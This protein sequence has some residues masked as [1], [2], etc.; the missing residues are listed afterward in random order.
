MAYSTKPSLLREIE[1]EGGKRETERGRTERKEGRIEG[2]MDA[3]RKGDQRKVGGRKERK[4]YHKSTGN[5]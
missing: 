4:S 1:R 3:G 2:R 5:H